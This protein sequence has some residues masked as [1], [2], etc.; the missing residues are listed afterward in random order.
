VMVVFL[1]V[2]DS[3]GLKRQE[4]TRSS[5]PIPSKRVS[6]VKYGHWKSPL[7]ALYINDIVIF[8]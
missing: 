2:E 6:L 4:E 7:I 5:F 1:E 8:S 3:H